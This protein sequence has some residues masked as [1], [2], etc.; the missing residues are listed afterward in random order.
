MELR[1]G[2]AT[3]DKLRYREELLGNGGWKT[4]KNN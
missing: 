4:E 1:N 3:V 2:E